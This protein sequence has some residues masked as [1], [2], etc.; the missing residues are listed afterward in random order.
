M[1]IVCWQTILMKSQTLFF[2]ISGKMS[3]N[4]S[5]VTVVIG[6]LRVQFT[7]EACHNL[8]VL[9]KNSLIL[10]VCMYKKKWFPLKFL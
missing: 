5:S 1:R 4:L 10:H 9:K 6:A 8:L 2:Q 7:C 3:Q